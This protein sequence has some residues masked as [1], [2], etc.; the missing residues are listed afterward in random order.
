MATT[1]HGTHLF[2]TQLASRI[3]SL[4]LVFE[5]LSAIMEGTTW[6]QWFLPFMDICNHAIVYHGSCHKANPLPSDLEKSCL[7]MVM[8]YFP[9]SMGRVIF[10]ISRI[11]SKHQ[12]GYAV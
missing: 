11:P 2:E 1:R 5:V 3:M 7:E 8:F 12:V 4:Y 10:G 6:L 9:I